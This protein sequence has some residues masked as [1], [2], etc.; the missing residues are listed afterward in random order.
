MSASCENA[1][2]RVLHCIFRT[3]PNDHPAALAV[4]LWMVARD[5]LFWAV[6]QPHDVSGVDSTIW[7]ALSQIVNRRLGSLPTSSNVPGW[8]QDRFGPHLR[9]TLL[10]AEVL[11]FLV[12][13][14]VCDDLI[15]LITCISNDTGL[16][17]AE[18]QALCI[19]ATEAEIQ[20]VLTGRL[21][22][23]GLI[24]A[25]K[26]STALLRVATLPLSRDTS[27]DLSAKSLSS[28]VR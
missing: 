28:V 5:D 21:T 13:S 14:A 6:P 26:A 19:G 20:A 22:Q 2:M 9:L 8:F 24:E 1:V 16:T 17:E 23:I 3:V 25:G 15:E 4:A 18:S 7:R 11:A 12:A 27:S 10:E